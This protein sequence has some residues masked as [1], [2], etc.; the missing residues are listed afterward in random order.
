MF[1]NKVNQN[2]YPNTYI[3]C[4]F[5]VSSS[6]WSQQS[7]RS[8]P[9]LIYSPLE[10]HDSHLK[11]MTQAL[12]SA[13]LVCAYFWATSRENLIS[14]VCDT[15]TLKPSAQLQRLA[16]LTILDIASTGV[17]LSWQ[18]T[19]KKLIGLCAVHGYADW[20]ASLLFINGINRFSHGVAHFSMIL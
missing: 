2:H 20:S 3:L 8:S 19:S 14:E 13:S 15:A 4:I 10:H 11:K 9:S 6:F 5:Q 16:R 18:P 1:S 7:F 12:K 17:I